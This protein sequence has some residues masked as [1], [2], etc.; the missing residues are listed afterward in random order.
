ML[1]RTSGTPRLHQQVADQIADLIRDRNFDCGSRLPSER[2]LAERF[3]VSRPTVREALVAIEIAG[4]IEVRVGSGAYVTNDR[5]A[6]ENTSKVADAGVSPFELLTARRLIEPSS[7]ALAATAATKKDLKAIRGAFELNEHAFGGSHWE[8]LEADRQFHLRIVEA[9]HN[10]TIVRMVGE[11]WAD[12]FGPI[13]AVL[14]ERTQV[15][16]KKLLTMQDHRTILSCIE[17][18]DASG[19]SAAMLTHLVHAEIKLLRASPTPAKREG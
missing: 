15:S 14:S 7:T 9:T 17:R 2:E 11:L 16:Q 8:R 1:T 3:A 19:A 5:S 13:F 18:R 4:L 12:M 6:V 10:S